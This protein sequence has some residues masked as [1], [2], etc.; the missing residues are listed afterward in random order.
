MPAIESK[1][2]VGIGSL[3]LGVDALGGFVGFGC[4]I[5]SILA[6][7]VVVP[8]LVADIGVDALQLRFV[9]AVSMAL[10]FMIVRMGA[11]VIA[12]RKCTVLFAGAIIGLA[13]MAAVLFA[14]ISFTAV[15]VVCQI[16]SAVGLSFLA[17]QWF[18]YLCSQPNRIIL[19]LVA[20]GVAAGIAGC[21]IEQYLVREAARIVILAMWATSF[22]CMV[23]LVRFRSEDALPLA[24][25]NKESD[26]RSKILWTSTIM[27][28][29][30]SFEFGF[31]VSVASEV[32]ATAVCLGAAIVAA[33]LLAVDWMNRR[34]ITERSMS[35]LKPPLTM[36]AFV[37]LFLFGDVVQVVSL[38]V[39]SALFSI[40][41]VFG[42]AAMVEH[43]RISRLA[44][45]RTF[46]K[47][48]LMD[49]CGMA[50]GLICGYAVFLMAQQGGLLAVQ[51]SAAIA[52]AYS[53]LAAFCHKARF[54]ESGV[55]DV[56]RASLP[57][58]KGLW[59]KRCR[60]V[61]EQHGL[62]ERQYEVLML[63]AQGRNAKY[64]EQTLTISLSTAQTHI[65][66]IYRKTGVHSRQEL[67]N[68]IENTK[69][70]GED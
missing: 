48:R 70:Y 39:L 23:A 47:A 32:G 45:L 66:N 28:S 1:G 16:V 50:F 40:Y 3:K 2:A 64:I 11:Y 24:I 18:S 31:T 53:F 41:T 7:F 60:A 29:F 14:P 36:L 67:L 37:A 10:G 68:L 9:Y 38:C 34:M 65:R 59:K 13:A 8:D 5:A 58:T 42:W 49:Y 4:T 20:A 57:E 44:P 46:S 30:S 19:M 27:L 61:S 35:P 55:E 22:G 51:V 25:G 56:G 54:P 12:R 62:S 43:V 52:I 17:L 21:L 69:L 15:R 63:V 26:K 33:A 6:L